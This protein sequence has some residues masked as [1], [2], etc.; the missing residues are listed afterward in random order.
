[1]DKFRSRMKS[2]MIIA[3]PDD[4]IIFG[5]I[6]MFKRPIMI[7]CVT[8]ENVIRRTEFE[9]VMKI[10]KCEYK[11]LDF[12]DNRN[13]FLDITKVKE[14]LR[15]ILDKNMRIITHN[16]TGEY[17]HNQHIELHNIIKDLTHNFYTFKLGPR[18][19]DIVIKRKYELLKIYNSQKSI[20][21]LPVIKNWIEHC[22][23]T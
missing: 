6:E 12:E 18:L 15:M 14:Q 13:G 5:D 11:L 3:H 1:M 9:N 21:S 4:E 22:C 20:F 2:I 23:I 10:L 7:I 17:G 8:T 19:P 16:S